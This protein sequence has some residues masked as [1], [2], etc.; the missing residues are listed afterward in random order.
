MIITRET[1]YALRILRACAGQEKKTA[2]RLAE[3]EHIPKQ[4]LYKI[5]QK[6]QEAGY[7]E[8]IR[9]RAGGIVCTCDLNSTSLLDIVMLMENDSALCACVR[10]GYVCSW[11]NSHGICSVHNE[12]CRI[13]QE[14]NL[15]FARVSLYDL[16]YADAGKEEKE[17][18]I[19]D[20]SRT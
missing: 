13:Q 7:V 9:G 11:A 2:S 14:L 18:A 16:F 15:R 3:S 19:P 4:Y 5:V 6:L 1:D 10:P 8:S 17:Y 20:L 12:L